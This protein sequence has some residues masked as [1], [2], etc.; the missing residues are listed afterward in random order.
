MDRR[1]ALVA[2][3]AVFAA[4]SV[5]VGFAAAGLVGDPFTDPQTAGVS[6]ATAQSASAPVSSA[7]PETTATSGSER[8]RHRTHPKSPTA[9]SR[10][11]SRPASS[12]SSGGTATA[13]PRPSA[14]SKAG[15]ATTS[16]ATRRTITTRAGLVS[17]T[18]R[19][20]LVSLSA[21]PAVG[22]SIDEISGGRR[23]EGKVKFRRTG[24]GEGE[25]EV[26]ARCSG[27]GPTFEQDDRE[28]SGSHDGSDD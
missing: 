3:W 22:W 12:G 7:A 1:L 15:S 27:G 28:G 10:A 26:H 23:E 17:G 18:C 9:T 25:L 16:D 24:D 11:T 21:S 2:L 14:T 8:P 13:R 5:G 19:S 20:G 6:A 4:A